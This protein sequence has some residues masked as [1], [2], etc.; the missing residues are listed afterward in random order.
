[1]R[2]AIRSTGF[3][4]V[5]G[6]ILH[7]ASL[8]QQPET[9]PATAAR[10]VG[11]LG[12]RPLAESRSTIA[13]LQEGL[14][15]LGQ[16]EGRDYRLEIRLADNDPSRYPVLIRELTN[17]EVELIVAASTPAA[18]A[19]HQVNPRMPIVVG[20]GPDLVG[21]GLASSME[22]PGGAV[23][24][25]EEL[26]AGNT[27]KSLRILHEAAPSATRVAVLS[28]AP[29]VDAHEMQYHEAEQAAKE[30]GL[31][32]HPYR[33]SATTDF[34]AVFP[35]VL[36]DRPDALL[37][38]GGVLPGPAIERI[39]Q[40][41]GSERLPAIYQHELYVDRGGLLAYAMDNVAMFRFAATYVDKI[42]KGAKPGDLPI[43]RWTRENALHINSRT[44]EAMGITL[45]PSLLARA[46]RIIR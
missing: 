13:A 23:T 3:L 39:V 38:L 1:M 8:A 21:A 6:L 26:N 12:L 22:H 40:F 28:P 17:L 36:K 29:T 7:D 2:P 14:R 27:A 34:D 9:K 25:I 5:L 43:T 41:A 10:L 11:Y 19:I 33:V 18:A 42:L 44:A 24:G 37:V 30:M 4:L 46:Q 31:V 15:E 16:V 45:P 32:L 35:L 20:R